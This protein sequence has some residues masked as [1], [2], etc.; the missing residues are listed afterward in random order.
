MHKLNKKHKELA[1]HPFEQDNFV[2][3][4]LPEKTDFLQVQIMK[5]FPLIQHTFIA[6]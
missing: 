6:Q 3:K 4:C 2:F 5:E 1:I